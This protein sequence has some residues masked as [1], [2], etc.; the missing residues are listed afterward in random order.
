MEK[1]V[2]MGS[3]P[4]SFCKWSRNRRWEEHFPRNKRESRS[5]TEWL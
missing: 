1:L 2:L 3:E 4:L 5:N